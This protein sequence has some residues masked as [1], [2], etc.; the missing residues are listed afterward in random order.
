M[1]LHVSCEALCRGHT[2]ALFY[3]VGRLVFPLSGGCGFSSA[4]SQGGHIPDLRL[5]GAHGV[6][7]LERSGQ[8]ND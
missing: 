3:P 6:R 4:R 8:A 7:V 5:G 2:C 1:V